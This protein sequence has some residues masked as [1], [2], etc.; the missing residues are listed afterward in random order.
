MSNHVLK[1]SSETCQQYVEVLSK[2]VT[3]LDFLLSQGSVATY[4][5]WGG[6]GQRSSLE[7]GA[8]V[9]VWS[10]L[11]DQQLKNFC[12][13]IFQVAWNK[14]VGYRLGCFHCFQQSHDAL[15][16]CQPKCRCGVAAAD[17]SYF[18]VVLLTQWRSNL[19]HWH[20]TYMTTNI[21]INKAGPT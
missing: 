11:E 10:K 20:L 2:S 18:T 8:H 6:K 12:H 17:R 9:V 13:R 19:F 21:V 1:V 3:F 4:C 15:P 7:P 14:C 16:H 5:R